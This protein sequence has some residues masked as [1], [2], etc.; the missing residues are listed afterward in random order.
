MSPDN[1]DSTSVFNEGALQIQRLHSLWLQCGSYARKGD[2]NKW[3]WVMDC[4]W[5]EL[6]ND[7][8]I[9]FKTDYSSEEDIKKNKYFVRHG[10][11]DEQIGDAKKSKDGRACYLALSNMEIFLR[12]LQDI[13][14]KGSKRKDKD[15]HLID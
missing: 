3:R 1:S 15:E 13:V 10:E 9:E 6:S 2:Y 11:I 14:G 4:V 7:A 8:L 12:N 5:R